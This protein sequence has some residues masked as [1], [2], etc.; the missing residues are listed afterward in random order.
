MALFQLN[1]FFQTRV[2]SL[3]FFLRSK[4]CAVVRVRLWYSRWKGKRTCRVSL[5]MR[6]K[7][8]RPVSDWP[9]WLRTFCKRFGSYFY[10]I[11][12][13]DTITAEYLPVREEY[14]RD[15]IMCYLEEVNCYF[16]YSLSNIKR[17][18]YWKES[19]IVTSYI[20]FKCLFIIY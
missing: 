9:G 16:V 12:I 3:T 18:H 14:Q 11:F 2:L 17:S 7:I 8:F 4:D 1:A 20:T 5:V 10:F 6:G 15:F 19:C 13:S